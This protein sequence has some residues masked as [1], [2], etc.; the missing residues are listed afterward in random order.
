MEYDRYQT[1][2]R[3]EI[4]PTSVLKPKG[5]QYRE[6]DAQLK[7]ELESYWGQGGH[8]YTD[9]SRK[10]VLPLGEGQREEIFLEIRARSPGRSVS[11]MGQS[12]LAGTRVIKKRGTCPQRWC[13]SPEGVH[14]TLGKG[15]P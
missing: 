3:H 12:L 11:T 4:E 2:S 6:L 7:K 9:N 15:S 14:R 10:P 13:M 5:L 8:T 1:K